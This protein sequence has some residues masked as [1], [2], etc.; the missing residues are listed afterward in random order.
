[1]HCTVQPVQCSAVQCSA[2]RAG[3][4]R[5]APTDRTERQLAGGAKGSGVEDVTQG[6]A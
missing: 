5:G 3:E 2:A 1:M 4:G 6:V